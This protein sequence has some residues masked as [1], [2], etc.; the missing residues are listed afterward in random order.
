MMS[1]CAGGRRPRRQRLTPVLLTS[2]V[3]AVSAVLL[4][5][6]SPTVHEV[7]TDDPAAVPIAAELDRLDA[8]GRRLQALSDGSVALQ[9][10]IREL[11]R[12]N[13]ASVGAW[14]D[15][16]ADRQSDYAAAVAAV[17]EYNAS[18]PE[19]VE[20]EPLT[21]DRFDVVDG[22]IVRT[23]VEVDVISLP[24][25]PK[26]PY[27]ASPQPPAEL[28]VD[29]GPIL[30]QLRALRTTL[31]QI[32]DELSPSS[33]LPATDK[34]SV[35]FVAVTD[36]PRLLVVSH[37]QAALAAAADEL[38]LV[39]ADLRAAFDEGVTSDPLMGDVCAKALTRLDFSAARAIGEARAALVMAAEENRIAPD[40]L[41]WAST[42]P[43]N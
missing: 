9:A 39:I 38:E 16:W 14:K 7:S 25:V 17:D 34:T 40:G 32:D 1:H 37:A 13:R 22:V 29:P 27:P 15:E 30:Q 28:S 4:S 18:L 19:P 35:A 2:L 5:C 8:L 42:T 11:A 23:P 33:S 20:Q 24:A 41:T 10:S 12:A 31:R 6:G 36:V 43:T 26:K 3:L 21:L